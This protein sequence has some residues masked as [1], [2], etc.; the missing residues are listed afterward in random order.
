MDEVNPVGRR[1][2]E[3][4]KE[5]Y[6]KVTKMFLGETLWDLA[7]IRAVSLLSICLN[8][9]TLCLV[10]TRMGDSTPYRFRRGLREGC[11]SSCVVFNLFRFESTGTFPRPLPRKGVEFREARDDDWREVMLSVLGIADDT[12]VFCRKRDATTIEEI[13]ILDIVGGRRGG[14]RRGWLR[15]CVMMN[16]RKDSRRQFAFLDPGLI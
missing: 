10:R 9:K 13:T 3:V 12:N 14:T 15:G 5:V 4:R 8:R 2:P 16:C 6:N 7:T 1:P 11:P